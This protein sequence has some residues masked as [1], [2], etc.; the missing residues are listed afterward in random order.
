M[1]NFTQFLD[2]IGYILVFLLGLKTL[3]F[4]LYI[5]PNDQIVSDA[6]L[7]V[8]GAFNIINNASTEQ[9]AVFPPLTR[10]FLAMLFE[11]DQTRTL[12]GYLQYIALSAS[13][14]GVALGGYLTFGKSGFYL[15]LLLGIFNPYPWHYASFFLSEPPAFILINISLLL[16]AFINRYHDDYKGLSFCF[17]I[18]IGIFL[19][20]A[21]IGRTQLIPGVFAFGLFG[22]HRKD[23]LHKGAILIPCILF[24]I[25]A[26]SDCNKLSNSSPCFISRNT[27]INL[28]FITGRYH[29]AIYK[30]AKWIPSSTSAAYS[31]NAIIAKIPFS[32]FDSHN[33]LIWSFIEAAEAPT[34]VL[35][36]FYK[37][38]KAFL[39]S[40]MWITSKKHL[41]LFQDKLGAAF[42]IF[43]FLPFIFM[44]FVNLKNPCLPV[45]F[46]AIMAVCTFITIIFT[47]GDPRYRMPLE[48]L[49]I[50][51]AIQKSLLLF[52][53]F[54][55]DKA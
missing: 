44:S 55:T 50:F 20:L 22:L 27:A 45:R 3:Y 42:V 54:S 6:R 2:P 47:L 41:H 43:I 52:S 40:S 34:S 28:P 29:G 13:I 8:K 9:D 38:A 37:N 10:Y 51:L 24:I 33:I 32:Q 35:S 31:P 12:A 26:T 21:C 11:L 17:Y 19:G 53:K 18:L 30:D 7:Y 48:S 1:R 25:W 14:F 36:Q 46:C 39:S 23:W 4:L 15:G 16:L 49:L 5:P